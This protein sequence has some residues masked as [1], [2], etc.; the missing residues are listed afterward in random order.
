MGRT[1]VLVR[2]AV[3]G[4]APRLCRLWSDLVSPVAAEDETS[5]EERTAQALTRVATDDLRRIVVAEVGGIVAGCAFL[6][7]A[8]LSPLTE[9]RVVH[10][11]HVQ[12]EPG[13]NRTGV[14]ES[15]LEAA[16]TWAE[17]HGIETVAAS[18]SGTDRESNR[19]L[20]RFGLAP[21]A[22]MRA[23]SAA[24]LRARVSYDAAGTPR[25]AG[26]PG[27]SVGQVVAARRSQRRARGR[28]LA[29]PPV[30]DLGEGPVGAAD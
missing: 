10:V 17:Q 18:V 24:A 4:D 11:S 15:L 16:L 12:V 25:Q 27:R 23:A 1:P 3:E 2:E 30:V 14:D 7:V 21:V 5:V 26:R 9:D 22:T 28:Q 20:A 19:I 13:F 29:P 8:Q 6:R